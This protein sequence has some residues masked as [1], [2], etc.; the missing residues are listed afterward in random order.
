MTAF[1]RALPR[2]RKKAARQLRAREA[3]R[4][5]VLA[6]AVRL[7]DRGFFRIGGEEYAE[8]NETYGLATLLKR[9]VRLD[10]QNV[11]VF[12]YTAKAGKRRIQSIVDPEVY[13]LV[14]EL[15]RRRGGGPELLAYKNG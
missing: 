13:R 8:E 11:L 7:L 1:A 10:E 9:H 12:D 2:I 5:R 14:G 15:K 3:S 6:G 4:D